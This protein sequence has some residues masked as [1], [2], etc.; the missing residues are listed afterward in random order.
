MKDKYL[1]VPQ[2]TATKKPDKADISP[3][4]F[5]RRLKN[6][7]QWRKKRLDQLRSKTSR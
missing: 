2:T 7:S 4:E 6:I 5:R 3:A 1:I